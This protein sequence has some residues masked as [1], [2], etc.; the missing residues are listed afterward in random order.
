MD[1]KVLIV[2]DHAVVRSGIRAVLDT[3]PGITVVG[4]ASDGRSCIKKALELKPDIVLM[5]LSMPNGRD[6]LYTTSELLQSM[7][8]VKVII[9]TMHSDE[10]YL[11]RALKSGAS[12]YVLKS[13]PITE[14]VTAIKQVQQ[15]MVYLQPADTKKVIQAYLHGN[16][17][18][19]VDRFETLTEREKEIFTLV[20]KGYTN[21]EVAE[22]LTISVKTVENHKGNI[23]EKLKLSN[24]RELMEFAFKRGLLEFD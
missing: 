3:K 7:P 22:L 18:D 21:K 23:M 19:A 9:L 5:D 12:G 4:E 1:I 16:A 14:L 24:R 15:G 11:F 10:Q 17:E 20:A 13:A 6:G 8:E 2:D